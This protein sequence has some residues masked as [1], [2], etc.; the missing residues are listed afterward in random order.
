VQSLDASKRNHMLLHCSLHVQT[1]VVALD[2]PAAPTRTLMAHAQRLQLALDARVVA[3]KATA[4]TRLRA[5]V[6]V[7]D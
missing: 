3:A 6:Q 1:L 2:I 7:T 5:S 4:G